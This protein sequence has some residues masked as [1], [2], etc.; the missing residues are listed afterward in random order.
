M[1]PTVNI[2]LPFDPLAHA[3]AGGLK[4]HEL[5]AAQNGSYARL[6]H[7]DFPQ[8]SIRI[9]KHGGSGNVAGK[10]HAADLDPEAFCDPTVTSWTGYI[11]LIDG[12]SLFFYFFESRSS[13][14]EDPLV[15]WTNGGPGASSAFGLFM[16]HGPCRVSSPERQEGPPINGTTHFDYS[17][18]TRANMI[19]VEQPA[20]VGYSYVRFGEGTWDAEQAGRDIYSFFRIF[21]SA[22]EQFRSNDFYLAGESYGGR[23]IPRFAA[24][25]VDQDAALL[26]AA[27]KAGKEPEAGTIMDLKGILIG[28]GVAQW[29]ITYESYYDM[30]CTQLS[31]NGVPRLSLLECGEMKAWTKRCKRDVAQYCEDEYSAENC[32]AARSVCSDKLEEVWTSRYNP[33]D[34]TDDCKAGIEVLCYA[35]TDWI[36]AYLDRDDVRSLVGAAPRSQTGTYKIAS[37]EVA[38]RFFKCQDVL[39]GSYNYIAGLLDRNIPVL[40]LSGNADF[41][42]NTLST[43]RYLDTIVYP[44]AVQLQKNLREWKVD[45]KRVGLTAKG[46]NLTYAT[47]DGA[48][49]LVPYKVEHAIP[50]L[51]LF[52]RW[53]AGDKI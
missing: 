27:K 48:P 42:C 35:E 45:G 22:F 47:I 23:Y 19:Y 8:M 49:H 3:F 18:N 52:N 50:A 4:P 28:N 21:F 32:E 53:L 43:I 9:K 2:E 7:R 34:V 44:G 30:A 17:W 24:E 31:G 16:E 14:E 40:V 5:V 6:T 10:A 37:K 46:G 36:A 38:S 15:F 26:A 11:D 20:G 12:K 41:V 51:A 13:P 39:R 33:Y 1:Q 29:S 25:M